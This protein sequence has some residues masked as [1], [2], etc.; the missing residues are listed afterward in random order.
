MFLTAFILKCVAY[1]NHQNREGSYEG[2]EIAFIARYVMKLNVNN[3]NFCSKIS[4]SLECIYIC[5][6]NEIC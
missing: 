4:Q 3:N 5:I 6:Q 2:N 1:F